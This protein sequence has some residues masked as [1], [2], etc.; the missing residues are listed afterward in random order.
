M[1]KPAIARIVELHKQLNNHNYR[2][3]VL[4]DPVIPDAEYDRLLREL[5]DLE[6]TYPELI[7]ADSPTQRVGAAP[8]SAFAQVHHAIPMLS[9]DNAFTN[10]EVADFDRRICQQLDTDEVGYA[11]EPKL[12]GLAVSLRYEQG[13]LVRGSTRGDGFVGEDITHNIRTLKTVPLRLLGQDYPPVLEVRGEVFMPKQGFEA[14]NAQARQ[15]GEKTFANPRNAA[16]GSLRQLDPRVTATRP[17]DMFCY[18]VGVVEGTVLPQLHSEIVN[19]LAAWGLHICSEVQ[20]V[21]GVQGC[22]DYYQELLA[23]RASLPYE[24]DGVVYK[25]DRLDQQRTLGFVA[26]AP[27]WAIA[28][29]FPAQ[30]ALTTVTDIQI[31]VGRT[32]ALTP[33]ARLEPVLVGGVTVTNATLHNVDE[34]HRKDVRVGDTVIVR[35]AGDVIPEIVKVLPE[36]RLDGAVSFTLP[37]CCPVCGSQV[38]RPEGET[39]ARCIGGLF[40]SAQRKEAI[41]HFASRRALDIEGLGERLVEQLVEQAGVRSPADLYDLDTAKLASLE[42]MG[43]KSAENLCQALQASKTTT[44][45]RFLYALGIREVGEAT[46]RI[47]ARHFGTLD[48]FIAA[49]QDRLQQIP[50]IGPVAAANIRAFFSEPHNREIISRLRLAGV[51]WPES[52]ATPNT[53]Q[54]LAGKTFVLTG[55]L[56]GMSRDEAKTRLQSLG[57]KV[58]GSVSAKTAYLVAGAEPGSKLAKAQAL[59]VTVLDEAGL[60]NLL[61][62]ASE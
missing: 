12:D 50:D 53:S 23:R 56:S 34:V 24:I 19:R 39:V 60:L 30:E 25:V 4:D 15:R 5:Q 32:G 61:D 59:G 22:L 54:V 6:Q 48:G 62:Q 21:S 52:D 1:A 9:L 47:L 16:A 37:E 40:C 14:L 43:P 13:V 28:H 35:R 36:R 7:T 11:A 44:L 38:I 51:H 20:L 49:D 57:A 10:E 18:G 45:T 31:Q 41:R 27:R 29:K 46:A 8:I 2:Y 26:R 3:Y 33:V 58:S 17:L 42:R 55:T